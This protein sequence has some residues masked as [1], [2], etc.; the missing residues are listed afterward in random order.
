MSENWCKIGRV[1]E[2]TQRNDDIN[3]S[4]VVKTVDEVTRAARKLCLVYYQSKKIIDKSEAVKMYF[5]LIFPYMN[6]LFFY[7]LLSFFFTG[8][9]IIII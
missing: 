8:I 5:F 3:R 4:L 9:I 7:Y 6:Y 1:R 2:V